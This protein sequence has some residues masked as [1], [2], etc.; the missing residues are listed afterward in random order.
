[1]TVENAKQISRRVNAFSLGSS[2]L[3]GGVGFQLRGRKRGEEEEAEERRKKRRRKK[4]RRK[5]RKRKKRKKWRLE[6]VEKYWR[7]KK[8][9]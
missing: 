6:K 2:V 8:S 1:M 7:R 5:K 4:R 3:H 9:K